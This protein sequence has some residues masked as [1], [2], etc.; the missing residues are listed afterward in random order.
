M[1]SLGGGGEGLVRGL[2]FGGAGA[3]ER[4]SC[5]SDGTAFSQDPRTGASAL[6]VQ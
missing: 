5:P 2:K 3:E 1:K 4:G 6:G